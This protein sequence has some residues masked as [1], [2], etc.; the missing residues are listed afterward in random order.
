MTLLIM[1]GSPAIAKGALRRLNKSLAHTRQ[2]LD[3]LPIAVT[4]ALQSA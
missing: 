3:S 4:V 1:A 2:P